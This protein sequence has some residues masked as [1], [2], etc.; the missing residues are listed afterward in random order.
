LGDNSVIFAKELELMR[1]LNVQWE[2]RKR[3]EINEILAKV[4]FDDAIEG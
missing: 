3:N 2:A 4:P 1:A